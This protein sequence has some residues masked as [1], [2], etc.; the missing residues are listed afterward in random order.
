MSAVSFQHAMVDTDFSDDVLSG[1]DDSDDDSSFIDRD[2]ATDGGD[3]GLYVAQGI[4][5]SHIFK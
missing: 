1:E 5:P 2:T 3:S 4:Q